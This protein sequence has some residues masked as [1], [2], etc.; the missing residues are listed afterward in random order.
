MM[1]RIVTFIA[2]FVLLFNTAAYADY[3]VS[4]I[5]DS[6][7][8]GGTAD[9]YSIVT[10]ILLD[11][12]SFG[13]SDAQSTID[14]YNA[15]V[16]SGAQLST[17][18][19]FYFKTLTANSA[20]EWSFE[21]PMPSGEYEKK[22]TLVPSVGNAEFIEYA[23]IAFKNNMLPVLI[24]AAQTNDDATALK[25]K[26]SLY[27]GYI[28]DNKDE[29]LAVNNKLKI[30]KLNKELVASFSP[31]DETAL[32]KLK[33]GI[34][35]AIFI[36][37]IEEG[38]ETDYSVV[39]SKAEYDRQKETQLT[40]EGK[41]KIVSTLATIDHKSMDDF[42]SDAKLQFYI[43]LVNYNKNTSADNLLAVLKESNSVLELDFTNL[44]RLSDAGKGKAAKQL[45]SKKSN[46]T[47]AMQTNLDT[48]S[49]AIYKEEHRNSGGSTGGGNFGGGTPS[50][51]ENTITYV[52]V[53]A[54]AP[55]DKAPYSDINQAQWASEAI[56]SLS[57]KGIIEGYED[58]SFK[59][60]N[61][62]TRAEFVKLIIKAFYSVEKP[63]GTSKFADVTSDKWYSDCVNLAFEKGIVSGDN[64]GNFNPEATISRQDMVCK[65]FSRSRIL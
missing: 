9:A 48:I 62:I 20:G 51:K 13:T 4:T 57:E 22:L 60:L 39:M 16:D 35:D 15:K 33:S 8:V 30:A 24:S 36:L 50:S 17:N 55:S 34:E 43:N 26:I 11:S 2:A 56:T 63:S 59:P 64:Y 31:S 46:S 19:I 3:S 21:V 18:D 58:N 14:A 37:D 28:Y 44:N 1:K 23:S 52:P 38:R 29:Y 47:A 42:K 27:L 54:P 5:K 32:S 53:V 49:D 61:S 6:I 10:F 12:T 25:D 7:S 45:A 40:D 65:R 41:S